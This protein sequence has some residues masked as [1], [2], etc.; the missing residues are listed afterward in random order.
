M[1][2]GPTYYCG[3]IALDPQT[4]KAAYPYVV[5]FTLRQPHPDIDGIWVSTERSSDDAWEVAETTY[6]AMKREE[7]QS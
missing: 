3:C 1:A 2:F 5:S 7:V 4:G 6:E